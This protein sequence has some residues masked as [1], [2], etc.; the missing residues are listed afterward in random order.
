MNIDAHD[1]IAPIAWLQ[2][3]SC[4]EEIIGREVVFDRFNIEFRQAEERIIFT[5]REKAFPTRS[6]S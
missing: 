1:F 4:L 6:L 2:D 5:W 3:D